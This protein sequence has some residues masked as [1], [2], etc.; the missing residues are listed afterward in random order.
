MKQSEMRDKMRKKMK[1]RRG[2]DD[3]EENTAGIWGQGSDDL[4]QRLKE[5]NEKAEKIM[6]ELLAE[7]NSKSVPSKRKR[8][9]KKKK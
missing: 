4:D 8:R 5:A 6:Q 3:K 1:E 7:E 2:G 9:G